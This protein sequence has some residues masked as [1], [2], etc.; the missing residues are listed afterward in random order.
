MSAQLYDVVTRYPGNPVL[1][2]DDV[3]Y[4]TP[5]THNAAACKFEGKYVLLFRA[6]IGDDTQCLGLATSEDGYHFEVEKEPV[7]MPEGEEEGKHVYDSRITRIEDTY[8]VT[9]ATE[10]KYGIRA[11]IATTRDF[12]TFERISLSEPDNRNTAPF[13]E[14]IGDLVAL[15]REEKTR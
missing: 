11:G 12:R 3:P 14:K 13:P 8:Y 7:M 15:C 9:Y 5:Y 4:E 2:A 6:G 10:S 1:T